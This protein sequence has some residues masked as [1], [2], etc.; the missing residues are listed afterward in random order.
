MKK[1]LAIII[2]AYKSKYLEETLLSISQQTCKNFNVYIGDDNSPEN[3][4]NIIASFRDKIDFTYHKFD[5]NL[6][7]V[8][9]VK[10]WERCIELSK[11]EKWI[12]LFSDDDIM[13]PTCVE[14]F[15]KEIE[16]NNQH[17]VYHFNTQII[18]SHSKIIKKSKKYPCYLLPYTF[19]KNKM[20]NR[21]DSFVVENIFSRK[22]Y[23]STK[24]FKVFDLAWGSDTA[25]WIIFMNNKPMKTIQSDNYILWRSSELNISPKNDIYYLTRKL[26]ALISFYEWSFNYFSDKKNIKVINLISLVKRIIYYQKGLDKDIIKTILN[27]FLKKYYST[28]IISILFFLLKIKNDFRKT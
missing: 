6:G 26:K 15:Y 17:H 12:W 10:H 21:I 28:Y 27:P 4:Y 23:D 14:D 24:G 5:S 25:S 19:Y 11:N 8:N 3:L 1:D 13:Q 18:D 9:L 16:K 22:I 20:L 2:P 7:G